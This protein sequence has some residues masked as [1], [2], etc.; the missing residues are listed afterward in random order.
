MSKN[1]NR[2]KNH[3]FEGK[4]REFEEEIVNIS[5]EIGKRRGLNPITTR[6]LTYLLNHGQLTQKQLMEL[7]DLSIGSIST[8][9]AAMESIGFV[10]KKLIQGTHTNIYSLKIDLGQNISSLVKIGLEYINQA[11]KFLK[12]KRRELNDISQINK[13]KFKPI[14]DRFE[15]LEHIMDFYIYLFG[16][17]ITSSNTDFDIKIIESKGFDVIQDFDKDINAIEYS[18]VDFF[19]TTP[20]FLG[21]NEI[22]SEVFAYFIT[23]KTLNQKKLRKLTNLSVGKVSIEIN[24]LLKLGIIE[25][26][27]KSDRGQL[28]YQMKSVVSAFLKITFNVLSEYIKWKNT[29]EKIKEEME[30]DKEKL[31]LLNGYAEV[32]KMV[33]LFL[34]IMPFYEKM[35]SIVL[36]KM[37][38]SKII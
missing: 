11:K 27:D 7:T 34:E 13:L 9:L 36:K 18:I 30:K 4:I 23:R 35:Y 2:Q 10:D 22:F 6:I 37:E 3:I 31:Q 14:M 5:I 28:T 29:I 12:V 19:I 16:I 1:E 32:L 21:K 33:D 26:V 25:I 17:L 15:E 8:N 20:M 24:K 38:K